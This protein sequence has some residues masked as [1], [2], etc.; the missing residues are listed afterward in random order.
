[1]KKKN[2]LLIL[3]CAISVSCAISIA[4]GAACYYPSYGKACTTLNAQSANCKMTSSKVCVGTV[5]SV[6]CGK[7]STLA[8]TLPTHEASCVYSGN[9]NNNC[10]YSREPCYI[11]TTYECRETMEGTCTY[12]VTA[13]GN[14]VIGKIEGGTSYTENHFSCRMLEISSQAYGNV[15]TAYTTL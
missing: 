11:E 9:K 4:Y 7:T 10:S 6:R 15:K 8:R 2:N 5:S 12:T 3:I 1:M 14:L 13:E